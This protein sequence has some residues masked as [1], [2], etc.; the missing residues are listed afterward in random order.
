MNSKNFV[1]ISIRGR[2]AYVILCFE[3]YVKVKYPDVDMMPVLKMMWAVVDSSDYIDNSAY[4]YL[5]IVP[6][7]LFEKDYYA[8]DVFETLTEDEYNKFI[9]LLSSDDSDLNTIMM[10]VYDI[11]MEYAYILKYLFVIFIPLNK[12]ISKFENKVKNDHKVTA[13]KDELVEIAKELQLPRY[14]SIR[15]IKYFLIGNALVF[16][17]LLVFFIKLIM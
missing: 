10:S 16:L 5:E 17:V 4:R 11:A 8:S 9:K 1:D 6:E 15:P 13:T 12:I 7:C 2:I 14:P 3:N